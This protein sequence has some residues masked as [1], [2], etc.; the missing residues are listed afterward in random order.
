MDEDSI[1][2]LSYVLLR[3]AIAKFK[4]V[5]FVVTMIK[6]II[7]YTTVELVIIIPSYSEKS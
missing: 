5:I 1:E 3:I 4:R 2:S 7:I 6:K